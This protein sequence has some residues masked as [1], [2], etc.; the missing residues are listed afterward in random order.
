M[1]TA[2]FG[3]LLAQVIP[4]L[5]IALVIEIRGIHNTYQEVLRER[6][7]RDSGNKGK[8]ARSNRVEANDRFGRMVPVFLAIQY[9]YLALLIILEVAALIV[10]QFKDPGI[11]RHLI[12]PRVCLPVIAGGFMFIMAY[13]ALSVNQ[14]YQQ[15]G[16]IRDSQRRGFHWVLR[17]VAVLILAGTWVLIDSAA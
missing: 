4:A 13:S 12:D 15:L 1:V 7:N 9:L 14:L 17:A 5:L 11:S 16:I 2:T 6:N 8:A 3:S 10:A